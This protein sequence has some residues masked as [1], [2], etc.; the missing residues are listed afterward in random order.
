[1]KWGPRASKEKPTSGADD[2]RDHAEL[3][4]RD[5]DVDPFVRSE[6]RD[7]TA[8]PV[9]IVNIYMHDI[10]RAQSSVHAGEPPH[11]RSSRVTAHL[12]CPTSAARR[13]ACD[14]HFQSKRVTRV[15]WPFN[16]QLEQVRT[17]IKCRSPACLA[18]RGNGARCDLSRYQRLNAPVYREVS[19]FATH[20]H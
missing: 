1:M 19:T 4:S 9:K 15:R 12:S 5:F 10:W 7:V 17:P 8:I 3:N 13:Q 11:H 18:P 14:S 2:S 20:Q 16:V 6:R